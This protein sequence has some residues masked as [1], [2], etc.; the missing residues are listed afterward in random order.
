MGKNTEES[1][2]DSQ[3]ESPENLVQKYVRTRSS[4]ES[5]RVSSSRTERYKRSERMTEAATASEAGGS[6]RARR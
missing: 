5:P 1:E 2:L 6:G 4:K 3:G